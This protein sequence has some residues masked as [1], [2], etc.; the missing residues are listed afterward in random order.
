MGA[1]FKTSCLLAQ[2]MNPFENGVSSLRKE[3]AFRG[4]NLLISENGGTKEYW[5]MWFPLK[6]IHI[7]VKSGKQILSFKSRPD[8][9]K[10]FA[11]QGKIFYSDKVIS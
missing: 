9:Q 1:T 3:F 10:G 8:L 5:Q 2:M 11:F 7:K 4:E 6:F